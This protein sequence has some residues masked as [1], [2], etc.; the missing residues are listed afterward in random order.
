[1]IR[2]HLTHLPCF[3][4]VTFTAIPNKGPKSKWAGTVKDRQRERWEEQCLSNTEWVASHICPCRVCERE[5]ERQGEGGA[6]GIPYF[7]C[8]PYPLRFILEMFPKSHL[9]VFIWSN[10]CFKTHVDTSSSSRLFLTLRCNTCL[11]FFL[12]WLAETDQTKVMTV[13]MT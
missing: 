13:R 1:M 7:L 4:E 3:S 2:F 8:R 6:R 9:S 12:L 5:R 11:L 10:Y